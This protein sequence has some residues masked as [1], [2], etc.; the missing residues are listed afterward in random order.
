[1]RGPFPV[2]ASL[3]GS[4]SRTICNSEL[5]NNLG[6]LYSQ[7]VVRAGRGGELRREPER[8]GGT[9]ADARSTWAGNRGLTPP[10]AEVVK[11]LLGHVEACRYNQR[12]NCSGES[13]LNPA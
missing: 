5:A 11:Q 13:I 10:L 7:R 8:H 3:A 9:G 6:N 12:C 1:M 4:G 2:T